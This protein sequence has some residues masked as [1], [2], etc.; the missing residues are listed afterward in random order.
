[1]GEVVASVEEVEGGEA[2]QL[3]RL[4]VRLQARARGYLIR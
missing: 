3:E 4:M 1:M 2:R